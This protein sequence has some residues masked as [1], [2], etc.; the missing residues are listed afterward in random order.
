M[1]HAGLEKDQF[2]TMPA[3]AECPALTGPGGVPAPHEPGKPPDWEP[4]LKT[5]QAR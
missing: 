1:I 5:E 4:F 2:V 3:E